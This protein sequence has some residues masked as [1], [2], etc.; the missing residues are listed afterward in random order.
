MTHDYMRHG[1]TTLFAALDVKSGTVIGDWRSRRCSECTLSALFSGCCV[2]EA[3]D[4]APT[5]NGG[6]VRVA[7]T[8]QRGSE[9]QLRRRKRPKLM[10]L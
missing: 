2:G 6:K 3:G 4:Y 1:T 8:C 10:R 7:A 9:G 5:A